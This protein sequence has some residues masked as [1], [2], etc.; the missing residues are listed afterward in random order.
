MSDASRQHGHRAPQVIEPQGQ[1]DACV[2]WLHGLGADGS[3]FVP[4]VPALGLSAGHGV[5]FVFPHAREL[6][7][8]V[9]GGMRMPAW[10]DILEMNLG[11]RVEESQLRESAAYVHALIEEQIVQGIESRR[12][13]LAGF[14][15]GGAVVYEAALS[16]EQPLGGLL[17][18]STYFATSATLQPSAA[19]QGL[20]ISVHH[21]TQDDV[22]PLSLG[23]AGAESA[24]ALGHP[25][26]WQAWPMAH[27][28]CLEEIEAI[29]EWFMARLKD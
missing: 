15:Q 7:V 24:R 12:I 20:D 5:R 29:G 18:L 6:A 17:A 3:D 16:C 1:V 11:R 9:N 13:I 22:V 21:G 27:A 26:E 25:V 23:E 28:V 4:V 2:I 14:S 10:Y 8:T 19:N